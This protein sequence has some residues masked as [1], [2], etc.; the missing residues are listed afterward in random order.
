M[1]PEEDGYEKDRKED[2]DNGGRTKVTNQL[3]LVGAR[4]DTSGK[5]VF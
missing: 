5:G 2:S 4:I 3:E 1:N